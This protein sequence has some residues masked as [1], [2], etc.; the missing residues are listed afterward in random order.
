MSKQTGFVQ[1]TYIQTHTYSI[2]RYRCAWHAQL[3]IIFSPIPDIIPILVGPGGTYMYT[4]DL[5]ALYSAS[6]CQAARIDHRIV[7]VHTPLD[8]LQWQAYL[9]HHPD[10]N[11]A[12][13]YPLRIATQIPHWS[14]TGCP[15][16]VSNNQHAVSYTK[17]ASDRR[18]SQKR[19]GSRQHFWAI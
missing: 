18:L 12:T 5:L 6:A 14:V 11:F 15:T 3:I 1:I 13:L 16:T 19:V 9:Q 17:S 7:H 8:T 10:A 4:T 2:L